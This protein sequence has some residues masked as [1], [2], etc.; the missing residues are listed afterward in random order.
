MVQDYAQS[1]EYVKKN[2]RK[3][4]PKEKNSKTTA[5]P[6]KKDGKKCCGPNCVFLLIVLAVGGAGFSQLECGTGYRN[7]Q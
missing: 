4:R 7:A 1:T 5:K 3:V 2:A 6:E